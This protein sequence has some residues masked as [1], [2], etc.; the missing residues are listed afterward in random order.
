VA[1]LIES[2]AYLA[3]GSPGAKVRR[4]E[5][6]AIAAFVR[7]PDRDFLNNAV[8]ARPPADFD[9]VLGEIE[10]TYAEHGIQRFAVWVHESDTATAGALRDRGYRF[11]SATRTMAMRLD[12]AAEVDPPA[13]EEPPELALTEA[14]LAEFWAVDGPAG[15]VPELDPTAAY[16]Y[17]ARLAGQDVAMLMAFDHDGDCGIY[18]VGT[19]EAARR[20]GI[21]TALSAHAVAAARE[22]GCRTA[23][24]QATAMA[25]A[26]YARVG[27]GDLG[28]WLEYVPASLPGAAHAAAGVPNQVS[29]ASGR[30]ASDPLP[31]QATWPSGRTRTAAGGSTSPITGSSQG[32]S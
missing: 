31:T 2:W 15:L 4:V 14:S 10:S 22:R 29:R 17:V 1:T 19:V 8:L 32:P 13:T 16:F 3:S 23:S 27:F 18:M 9:A 5:E 12:Q 7:R 20:R 28:R 30:P 21:A 24:L 26:V 6:A 25:E 11:D